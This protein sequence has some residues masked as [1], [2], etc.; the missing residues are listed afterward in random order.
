[1]SR[2]PHWLGV[3]ARPQAGRDVRAGARRTWTGIARQL[4]QQYPDT[5]TQMGVHLEPLHDSFAS[6]PR[7]ALLML[8]GAVGLLF[9]IVCANIAN[10]QLGRAVSRGRELAIR[11]AL[12]AGRAAAAATAVDRIRAALRRSAAR[13]DLAAA[14][15]GADH[16]DPLR[17]RSPCRCSPKSRSTAVC[18]SSPSRSRC[19]R[20]SSLASFPRSSSSRSDLVTER[21]ESTS[22]RRRGFAMSSWPPRSRCRSCS[23]SAPCCWCAA[24]TVC[25]TSI[26]AS[27]RS[28]R[29]PSR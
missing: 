13:S 10:L 19:A 1:M 6:E 14:V 18:C 26:P 3:V 27:T 22:R 4:E 20:R 9:L 23:S 7:T 16:A 28:M 17:G 8:S 25:R 24:S 15:L 29:S 2:R 5:N 11:R 21:S 12:G